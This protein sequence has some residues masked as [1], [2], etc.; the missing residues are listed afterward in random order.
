MHETSL[1]RNLFEQ[2]RR[3]SAQHPGTQVGK[4][5]IEVGPLSGI[6]P[7][8]FESAFQQLAPLAFPQPVE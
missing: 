5:E 2:V 3:I 7:L 6:E 8:L 1:V 4:V